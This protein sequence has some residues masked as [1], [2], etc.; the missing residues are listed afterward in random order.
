MP[1]ERLILI[2]L[3]ISFL[4][5]ALTNTLIF[6][7]DHRAAHSVVFWS[8]GGFGLARWDTLPFAAGG[9]AVVGGF[10]LARAR[11]L[12]GLLAG[13]ETAYSLGIAVERL[14]AEVFLVCALATASFV[15]FSGVIGF[16]GLM[17]PHCARWWTGVTHRAL[18]VTCALLG[19]FV[20]VASD[21]VARL[22]LAPPGVAGGDRYR[23]AWCGVS[24]GDDPY[25]AEVKGARAMAEDTGKAVEGEEKSRK[26]AVQSPWS[27]W[28]Q[29]GFWVTLLILAV[30]VLD[31]LRATL[32]PFVLGMAIAYFL[33]PVADRL[34]RWGCSRV[35][36][37][38]ILALLFAILVT[39]IIVVAVP[40]LIGQILSFAHS[41]PELVSAGE[42]W[43]L[44][45]ME[46][47]ESV[48][49]TRAPDAS[50]IPSD[51]GAGGFSLL[52]VFTAAS[53]WLARVLGRALTS[54]I[55]IVSV[56]SLLVITPVVAF[57][58]LLDWDRMTAR[59]A[60][61][62]PVRHRSV[63]VTL[64]REIDAVLS[65]FAR[66]QILVCTTLGIFYAAALSLAGLNWAFVVA[67]V[68]AVTSVIPYVGTVI[69]IGLSLGLAVFQFD[70]LSSIAL[71][72]AIF[73]A[74]QILEGYVLTPRFVGQR[75]GLHPVWVIFAILT[76][77][78][79]AGFTGVLVAVP[80]AAA[81]GVLAR[82]ALERYLASGL[83]RG[84]VDT[85]GAAQQGERDPAV[86]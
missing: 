80:V 76:G 75:I 6:A 11:A 71:I 8:L 57:Y 77:G 52:E 38:S 84:D 47:V 81:L 41:L 85:D 79:L 48:L 15:A 44:S 7:G 39:V 26:G 30:V 5:T 61:Y 4:F 21:L 83:Y 28:A 43:L 42:R 18:I 55:E 3:A 74:G 73:V 16:L 29:V 34:E 22:L 53:G 68:V 19:A 9:L 66:G 2:G 31:L 82:F 27:S 20:A 59:I 63:I 36:A 49:R 12:D 56:L 54:G 58:L 65:G 70:R 40:R 51:G 14:R 25:A 24:R 50:M 1:P 78:S 23:G 62:L 67:L 10:A 37:V 35:V 33:D 13:E 72:A 45:Q 60:G 69:G 64:L 17:V 86:R 46:R 32:L